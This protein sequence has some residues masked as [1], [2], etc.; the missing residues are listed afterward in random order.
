MIIA[1]VRF[2]L[3][4]GTG[5]ADATKAYEQSAPRYRGLPGLVR[6]HY[7]FDE[8]T[9]GGVY[10]WESREAA[11]RVYT[12]EWRRSIAEAVG[13]RAAV[14]YLGG[15]GMDGVRAHE[16]EL[17]AYALERLGEAPGVKVFGP[18]NP[19]Q[20]AGVISFAMEG[21]HPH[22]LAEVCG[23]SGVCVRAGHHCAQP[24]MR[25]LGVAATT[26]ASFHVYNESEDVDRLVDA[27]AEARRVFGL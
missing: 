12:P 26:R 15:L 14:D 9:G 19:D 13:L 27:L 18:P 6:K 5:V 4:P 10:V 8:G 2:D 22:D 23:R 16:R 17:T 21:I 11:E 3:P 1:L 25:R 20:H 24:L 7:L